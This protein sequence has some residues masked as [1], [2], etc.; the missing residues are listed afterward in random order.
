MASVGASVITSVGGSVAGTCVSWAPHAVMRK[1]A[2]IRTLRKI[3]D[4]FISFVSF[5]PRLVEKYSKCFNV[6]QLP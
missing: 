6:Q 3:R 2:M 4:L 1:A 5:I